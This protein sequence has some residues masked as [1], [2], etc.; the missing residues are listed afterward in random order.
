VLCGI[1]H[2]GGPA[3]DHHAPAVPLGRVDVVRL[4]GDDS[5]VDRLTRSEVAEVRSTTDRSVSRRKFTGSTAGSAWR[6]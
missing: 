2:H 1:G 6:V 5:P 4:E 3:G